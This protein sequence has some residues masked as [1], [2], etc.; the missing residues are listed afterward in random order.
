MTFHS[1]ANLP[2]GGGQVRRD[3]PEDLL[4]AMVQQLVQETIQTEF[5]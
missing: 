5:D 1:N 4:R 2:Q 3:A